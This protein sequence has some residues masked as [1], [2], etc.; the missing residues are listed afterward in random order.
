MGDGASRA[1]GDGA[2]GERVAHPARLPGLKGPRLSRAAIAGAC[3]APAAVF[4]PPLAAVFMYRGVAHTATPEPARPVPSVEQVPPQQTPDAPAP[5]REPSPPAG[6]D[7]AATPAPSESRELPALERMGRDLN[8]A[9][10]GEEGRWAAEAAA[11]QE[12]VEAA[13]EARASAHEVAVG[14]TRLSWFLILVLGPLALLGLTA[15]FGTTTLGLVAIAHIRHSAGRLYGMG[16]AVFD[17]LL[18]PLLVLD[19]LLLLLWANLDLPAGILLVLAVDVILVVLVWRLAQPR[20]E[21]QGGPESPQ[22]TRSRRR[23]GVVSVVLAVAGLVVGA[24]AA[25]VGHVLGMPSAWMVGYS[26]FF[27]LEVAALVCG[28]VAWSAT[29]TAKAG[30]IASAALMAASLLM[31]G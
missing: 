10:A 12:A 2:A 26:A 19:A 11:R 3:W 31:L 14:Q 7:E 17:A 18:F 23:L 29:P 24:G 21:G 27:G 16:L 30:A 6:G 5:E 1:E 15:P 20:T 13:A 28:I 4:L 8:G 9:S 22:A 25:A